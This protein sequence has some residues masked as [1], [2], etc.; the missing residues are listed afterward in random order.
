MKNRKE[1]ILPE[2]TLSETFYIQQNVRLYFTYWNAKF[3]SSNDSIWNSFYVRE[4]RQHDHIFIKSIFSQYY[5]FFKCWIKQ[6]EREKLSNFYSYPKGNDSFLL[7]LLGIWNIMQY[8]QT[9]DVLNDFVSCIFLKL[10]TIKHYTWNIEIHFL[11]TISFRRAFLGHHYLKLKQN[12]IH[13]FILHLFFIGK[14]ATLSI[15]FIKRKN[16]KQT[17]TIIR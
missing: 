13:C 4:R 16:L 15:S 12:I 6:F 10:F 17:Y 5:I 3:Q 9:K 14:I 1:Y 7:W 11:L 8:F 2:I